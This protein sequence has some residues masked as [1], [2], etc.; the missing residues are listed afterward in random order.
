MGAV[1]ASAPPVTEPIEPANLPPEQRRRVMTAAISS[2]TLMAVGTLGISPVYPD[3]ARDL[4]LR[5]DS[6]GAVLGIS[7]LVAGVLQIPVGVLSDRIQLK[8]LGA[9]GLVAAACAP[10]IWALSPNYRV[11]AIGQFTMGICIVCLQA[12][13][14][15][16]VAKTFRASGRAAAMSMLFVASSIGGVASLLLFGGIGGRV[17]WRPVAL[18]VAVLPL[19]ALPFV[20]RMPDVAAGDAKK[21]ISEIIRTSVRYVVH[22]RAL[23]L[24][25]L[26]ILTAAAALATQFMIPFVLR[27]N[28][29]GAAATGLLLVPYI[30]GG[31]IGAP[32]MGRLT[33]LFGAA[34]PIAGGMLIGAG[35]LT[36]LSVIGTQPLFMIGCFFVLG[37]LAN[38]GQAVLLS[39][40]A[41]LASRLDSVG[42]GSALGITRLA[43]SLGPAVSPSII[44]FLLL[45]EGDA[46]TERVIAVVFIVCAV[47]AVVVLSAL[48]P[49]RTR[50]AR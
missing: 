50:S 2:W 46:A 29:Y 33:D 15:T 1:I 28:S 22:G 17:G 6:F 34:R 8:Y 20:A 30:V 7:T 37:T 9:V 43:Q 45:N 11:Y 12:A 48:T 39:S 16:A 13:F 44:G 41:E 31:L 24:S 23:A 3:I 40:A 47:L 36:A 32:L 25:V 19:L 10:V 5:A 21:T 4:G 26:M 14:H 27:S 35:S 18:G 42:A 49:A 38:G